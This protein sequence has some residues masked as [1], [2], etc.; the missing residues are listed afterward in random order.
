MLSMQAPSKHAPLYKRNRQ[1]L[2]NYRSLPS[3]F[4]LR[5]GHVT[6]VRLQPLQLLWPRS[7]RAAV[8]EELERIALI[9]RM[10][11]NNIRK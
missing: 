3:P 9:A 1:S 6:R 11:L 2:Q 10:E 5:A 4:R 8:R 7:L